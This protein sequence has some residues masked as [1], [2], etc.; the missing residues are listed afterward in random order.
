MTDTGYPSPD[1]IHTRGLDWVIRDRDTGGILTLASDKGLPMALDYV[2]DLGPGDFEVLYRPLPDLAIEHEE[3]EEPEEPGT[4][5]DEETEEP[6]DFRGALVYSI[7]RDGLDDELRT[8]RDGFHHV[9]NHAL[10][11]WGE[12]SLCI[13]FDPGGTVPDP[14][15]VTGFVNIHNGDLLGATR[16]YAETAGYLARWRGQGI[17]VGLINKPLPASAIHQ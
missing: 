3:P 8:N 14:P 6:F 11:T 15:S 10:T 4:P 7:R 5:D 1:T 16:D 12:G 9:L 2:I 17:T 13:G